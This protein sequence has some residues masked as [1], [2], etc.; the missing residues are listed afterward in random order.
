[1][2]KSSVK[3]DTVEFIDHLE[4]RE[5]IGKFCEYLFLFGLLIGLFVLALLVLN[6]AHDGLG[7]LLTPG[8]LTETPSRFPERGGIRPAIIGSFYLGIIVL[9]VAVPIGVG[10]ALYLEEYAP[11]TWWTALI[12][13]NIGN[14]AGVPSIVYGLLGLAVFNYLLNFGPTLISGALTLALLSLPVIIVTAR[15][16]I[17]AV[18]D[19]LRQASYGLGST[20]WQT[21]QHHVLPYAVPGILTG[22]IISVSRAIGDAA[23][24]MVVGAV[25]FLTFDPGLFQRFMA[26]PIQIFSYI[27][28][29]EPGFANAA[30]AAIIVLILLILA[31]NAIAI[32]LR[33]RYSTPN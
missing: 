20:K 22:V 10:S 15:E 1:M 27:T 11:K 23:S 33:Q 30:A 25:S 29:P 14:L 26:L 8:F 13:V 21:I 9:L 31:L 6:I 16:A 32:Y 7:R 19:S 18:P 12:E 24:L 5:A 17:R 3:S 4:R 28:R 2:V